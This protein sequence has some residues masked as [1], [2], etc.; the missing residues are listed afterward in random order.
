[1][2]RP[3]LCHSLA[4]LTHGDNRETIH[5]T[6][7]KSMSIGNDHFSP[8]TPVHLPSLTSI[9]IAFH[10][11]PPSNLQTRSLR[12][13]LGH[14][15]T[16]NVCFLIFK[17]PQ[18]EN[19]LLT[20]QHLLRA[21]GAPLRMTGLGI[22]KLPCSLDLCWGLIAILSELPL[23]EHLFLHSLRLE[24]EDD[25]NR[26]RVTTDNVLIA[27]QWPEDLTQSDPVP[28]RCAVRARYS[29]S[30][31]PPSDENLPK[32]EESNI[33]QHVHGLSSLACHDHKSS[34]DGNV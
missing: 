9:T 16:P 23:L 31:F 2:P 3:M 11:S 1:M 22:A 18:S 33:R 32:S 19:D 12:Y 4:F 6:L 8:S 29:T 26:E 21:S 20:V 15:R 10:N 30:H 7:R 27:L 14:L 28:R 13:L 17:E 5:L 24:M 25:V 34:T